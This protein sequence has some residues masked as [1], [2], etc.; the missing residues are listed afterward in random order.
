V[1]ADQGHFGIVYS[2][3]MTLRLL[4]KKSQAMLLGQFKFKMYYEHLKL[5]TATNA[6]G[7][8]SHYVRFPSIS[9]TVTKSK[10]STK[11]CL[12]INRNNLQKSI[13]RTLNCQQ[14]GSRH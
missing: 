10:F 7:N 2:A 5:I 13:Q 4:K 6:Y 14:N 1:S 9:V 12:N 11:Y 3:D 8:R